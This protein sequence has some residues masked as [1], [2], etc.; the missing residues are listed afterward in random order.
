MTGHTKMISNLKL[1]TRKISIL[2]LLILLIFAVLTALISGNSGLSPAS[3]FNIIIYKTT[4]YS[5]LDMS[6][7]D[8]AIVWNMRMPRVLMAVLAGIA[9]STAG[10]LYQGCFRNPLVEP[11]ILGASSGAS[12]GASAAIVFPMLF[13]SIQIS[14]F[15]FALAAVTASYFLARQKGEI[16]T[17]GLVLSGVIIGSV[18]SALVSIMKYLSEDTQLREITFWMMGG[19]YHAAWDDIYINA[20]IIIGCFILAW[21]LAWKL[22]LLSIGDEEAKSL[23]INPDKYKTIFIITATLMTSVCVSSVGIIAWVGLMM[24][25]AARLLTGPDN[26]YVIPLSSLAGAIYLLICDTIARTLTMGEI[27]IGIITSILGAPFLIWILRAK[28]GGLFS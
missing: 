22:N 4:G 27:P 28:S 20:F 13:V 2:I 17:V 24:P 12:F 19:L 10:A 3:V 23:G 21:I 18:F 7:S 25:H 8:I 15:V 5:F 6:K 11:F 16:N 14:A 1:D 26:R 9:L